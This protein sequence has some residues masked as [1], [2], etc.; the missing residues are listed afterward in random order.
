MI[1]L[2]LQSMKTSSLGSVSFLLFSYYVILS[3]ML[4]LH[5]T[6]VILYKFSIPQFLTY[7]QEPKLKSSLEVDR[8]LSKEEP[9]SR[10]QQ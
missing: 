9:K 8:K 5:T 7:T 6:D 1:L 10:K 4:V 2:A 3:I